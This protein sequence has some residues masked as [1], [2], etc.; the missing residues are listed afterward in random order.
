MKTTKYLFFVILTAALSGCATSVHNRSTLAQAATMTDLQ[1]GMVLDNIAMLRK[2]PGSLPWHT[3]YSSGAVT[4]QRKITPSLSYALPAVNR[5]FGVSA[6]HSS[7][8]VWT[9]TPQL[10]PDVLLSVGRVYE[11]YVGASWIVTGGAPNECFSGQYKS[12]SV[13][14]SPENTSLLTKA[15]MDVLKAAKKTESS[16][17]GSKSGG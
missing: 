3:S 4:T 1:Y 7:Q 15:V 13:W 11:K 5:V 2:Y 8:H 9:V 16:T 14:V 10:D 12:T 6:E 17:G